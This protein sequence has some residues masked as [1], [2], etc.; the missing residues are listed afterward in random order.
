[1]IQYHCAVMLA[2]LASP[3]PR[4]SLANNGM[5]R[6][7]LLY[8]VAHDRATNGALGPDG[9]E[10]LLPDLRVFMSIEP[11]QPHVQKGIQFTLEIINQGPDP[12]E[13]RDPTVYINVSVWN[14]DRIEVTAPDEGAQR[15]R[16]GTGLPDIPF[17][18]EEAARK[19][20]R[21]YRTKEP[22]F[23][24][25]HAKRKTLRDMSDGRVRLKPG[26][27]FQCVVQ[28]AETLAEPEAY[29][30]EQKQRQALWKELRENV[31]LSET[32]AQFPL[33]KPPKIAPI[34]AGTYGLYMGIALLTSQN[35]EAIDPA[36]YTLSGART[37]ESRLIMVHLGE[38]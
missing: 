20:R 5:T 11:V 31:S 15:L 10:A 8:P 21:P 30:D 32:L 4:L 2:I 7:E 35:G 26:E 28:V 19:A 24:L 18:G 34:P 1:M 37:D 6:F 33:P 3:W 29:R 13:L 25:R 36:S 9:A 38:K 27:Q 17:A 12:V 16:C 14:S 22:E 23:R